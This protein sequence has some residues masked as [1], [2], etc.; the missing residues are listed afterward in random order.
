MVIS[1]RLSQV[2]LDLDKLVNDPV[3]NQTARAHLEAGAELINLQNDTTEAAAAFVSSALE[4]SSGPESYR[5]KFYF[6]ALTCVFVC[7]LVVG[8]Q[9]HALARLSSYM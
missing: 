7:V 4:Y 1:G 8:S 9:V 6:W 2:L 5:Y 3:S